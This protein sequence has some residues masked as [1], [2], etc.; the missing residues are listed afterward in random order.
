[1]TE[2]PHL[3]NAPITEAVIDFRAEPV[4]T[5][6]VEALGQAVAK[7]GYLGYTHKGYVI[8]SEFGFSVNIQADPKVAESGGRA[9]N[10]GLRLHSN[11]DKY[12]AQLRIDGFTLSR[13]AP[14]ESWDILFQEARRLWVGYRQ[15]VGDVSIT[16]TATRYINNLRLPAN[17]LLSRYL[18]L[19]P[20]IPE[21]LPQNL[22]GFLH[23]YMLIDTELRATVILNQ[24]LDVRA[25]DEPL[26]LIL[27]I[28]AFQESRYVRDDAAAWDV[29][30]K[31]RGLKNRVFFGCLTP[32]GIQL[33]Q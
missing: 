31:L 18:T 27:D 3:E 9:A 21:G 12:V 33:Y 7:R 16:R 25:L 29:L 5:L 6:S 22:S 8:R 14:Y 17:E 26:P 11:D 15:C 19:V 10:L 13:L 4:N 24:A 30:N 28:D 23:R 20:S 2:F 32:M 1:M